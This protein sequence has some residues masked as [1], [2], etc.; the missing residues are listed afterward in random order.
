MHANTHKYAHTLDADNFVH[1]EGMV[2]HIDVVCFLLLC[3]KIFLVRKNLAL[4]KMILSIRLSDQ[5]GAPKVQEMLIKEEKSCKCNLL[6]S[7]AIELLN[8]L[9]LRQYPTF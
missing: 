9:S 4:R 2:T 5:E 7:L 3:A 1:C 8:D 6:S